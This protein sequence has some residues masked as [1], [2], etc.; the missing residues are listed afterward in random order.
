MT[1]QIQHEVRAKDLHN[2]LVPRVSDALL[3]SRHTGLPSRVTERNAHLRESVL[4][5]V[6]QKST[7]PQVR[8][9]MHHTSNCKEFEG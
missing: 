5:V 1:L 2:R 8:Q 3:L 9:R 4:Q 6:L 7:P